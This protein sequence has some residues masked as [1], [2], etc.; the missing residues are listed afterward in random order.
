[1]D[2]KIH[3]LDRYNFDKGKKDIA[4][5]NPDNENGRFE[6][7]GL[8]KSF[9]TRGEIEGTVRWEKG[10]IMPPLDPGQVFEDFKRG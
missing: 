2:L 4:S 6:L 5:G 8:A 10:N 3:E 9:T 7:L 1:M